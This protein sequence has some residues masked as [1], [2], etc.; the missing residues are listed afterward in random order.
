M[1]VVGG[2]G[3]GWNP[4]RRVRRTR[5][6]F[7]DDGRVV[8][9]DGGNIGEWSYDGKSNVFRFGRETFL[10]WNG[11]RS[12]PTLLT[13]ERSIY[14]M[15]GFVIGW[16]PFSPLGVWGLWQMYR[17]DVSAEE[18]GV[19]PWEEEEEGEEGGGE[20]GGKKKRIVKG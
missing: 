20:E 11:R 1:G 5:V 7:R 9:V 3:G 6:F 12:F 10:S 18:R 8:W 14:Y 15:Q 4:F 13:E 16:A 19:A 17:D 2:K